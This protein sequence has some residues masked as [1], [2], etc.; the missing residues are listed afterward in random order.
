MAAIGEGAD[1]GGDN[2]ARAGY[3]CGDAAP[4]CADG[5]LVHERIAVEE[6][7]AADAGE[8]DFI[9]ALGGGLG[10]EPCVNAVDGG[11][12]HGVE[13]GGDVGFELGVGD[14]ADVVRKA[15]M[16]RDSGGDGN[17]VF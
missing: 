5:K 16:L 9:A 7:V 11:L 13:D 6:L 15:V 12:V 17:F 4:A 1:G 2:G 3:G 8:D 10:G 14:A